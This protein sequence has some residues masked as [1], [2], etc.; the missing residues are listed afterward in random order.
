MPPE[1][2]REKRERLNLTATIFG[3]IIV[4]TAI[5]VVGGW[6]VWTVNARFAMERSE[7]KDLYVSKQWFLDAHAESMK[8]ME[9]ISDDVSHVKDEV[10]H[11]KEDVAQIK[12]RINDK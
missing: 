12:G 2:L 6:I 3:P 8:S 11:V 7:M 9:R 1:Q 5:A 4:T 10:G